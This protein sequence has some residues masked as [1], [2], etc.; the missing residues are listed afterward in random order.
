[1]PPRFEI[2]VRRMKALMGP[3]LYSLRPV[4][5]M[6]IQIGQLEQFPS[7]LLSG[8]RER[9][10]AAVPTLYTHKCSE[11]VE[12]GFLSRVDEGTWIGHIIEHLA[13]ELQFLAGHDEVFGRTRSTENEGEYRVIFAIQD[14]HVARLTAAKAVE[15]A[16][17]LANNVAYDVGAAIKEIEDVVREYALG[18]STLGIVTEAMSRGI[19]Y[20]RL[21]DYNLVQFGH[22]IHQQRIQATTTSMTGMIATDLACDKQ[23]TKDLLDAGGIPVPQGG[24]AGDEEE[25]IAIVRRIGFPVVVKPQ[26]GNHGRGLCINI[27]DETA[28]RQATR[29]ALELSS[30]AIVEQYHTGND[31]RALVVNGQLVAVSHRVPPM[32]IGDGEHTVAQLVEI[33]NRDPRRGEGHEKPLTKIT[34]DD[35]A[36]KTLEEQGFTL[37]SVPAAKA[38]VLLRYSANLSVGGS[39][40]DFTD[41]IHID[42][43]EMCER[44][45]LMIGLDIAG[46]DILCPDLSRPILEVGGAVLEINAAPGF[47]MHLYPSE[48][49]PRNVAGPVMD[50]LFPLGKPARIPIVAVTGTNGKT[51]T[52]RL[53][54]HIF[55]LSGRKTGL[56]TSD[57]IYINGKAII[58]GDTTGPWSAKVV[59]RNPTV[60][61]AVLETARGGILRSGLGFDRCDVAV[62]TNVAGDHLGMGGVNTLE[63]LARVKSTVVEVVNP[64]GY[65]VLNAEDEL[66]AEMAPRCPGKV[67]WFS[68]DPTHERLVKHRDA[69]DA[70]ITVEDE[71]VVIYH[72][73][74]RATVLKVAEIPCTFGGA[75]R[76]N[77]ANV[78]AAALGAYLANIKIPDLREGLRT[79]TSSYHFTPGRLNT[80]KLPNGTVLVDYAHNPHAFVALMDMVQRLRPQFRRCFA[81][82]AAPGDRLDEQIVEMARIAGPHFDEIILKEDND[83]RGREH[84]SICSLMERTLKEDGYAG[85][86]EVCEDELTAVRLG[87]TRLTDRDLLLVTGD[88]IPG[89]NALMM[90]ERQLQQI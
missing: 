68:L 3:N 6:I 43:Q 61:S 47:R 23:A 21:N 77:L 2:D 18:P 25:A 40:I 60:D 82:L 45:A 42:N 51:T 5:E 19:P 33:V 17:A 52:S 29:I 56:T 49:K 62:I 37:A 53:L 57:G 20:F 65:A 89:I 80:Y 70:V 67:S 84:G 14:E 74:S 72:H 9:L 86:L 16:L 1:M 58:K 26:D 27:Q 87:L 38:P 66:V 73:R 54:S 8:F 64:Y 83:R 46:I 59:L 41:Q 31:Y 36:I 81:V 79:F 34:V 50:M 55:K 35:D 32:V 78:L 90:Q 71:T 22:G 30:N 11:G 7:N 69:G 28:L 39:A 88:D 10:Q 48:G 75:S 63:D 76:F 4:L 12:G 85:K 44:A 24:L 15:L 13:L